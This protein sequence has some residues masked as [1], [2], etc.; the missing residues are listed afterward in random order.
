MSRFIGQPT[1]LYAAEHDLSAF[2][3]LDPLLTA[4]IV[5]EIELTAVALQVALL[6][7]LINAR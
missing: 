6:A 5:M 3:V 2:I 1:P 7:V 4:I